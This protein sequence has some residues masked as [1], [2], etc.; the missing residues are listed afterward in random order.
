M[1]CLPSGRVDLAQAASWIV[2]NIDPGRDA[3][4]V[5]LRHARRILASQA[6]FTPSEIGSLRRALIG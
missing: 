4:S 1:P 2:A 3:P 5:A 6:S